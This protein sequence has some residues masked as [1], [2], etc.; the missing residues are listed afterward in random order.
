MK[1]KTTG[2][3]LIELLTVIAI[4]GILAGIIIPVVGSVRESANK[5]KTKTMFSQWATALENFRQEYGYYPA[6][7][8][9][10]GKTDLSN[11]GDRAK[12][13]HWLTGE[14]ISGYEGEPANRRGMSFYSFSESELLSPDSTTTDF[15]IKNNPPIY[16][17]FGNDTIHIVVDR[18]R[19]GI[20]PEEDISI[21][22]NDV[23]S[24]VVI[25]SVPDPDKGFVLVRNWSADLE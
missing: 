23:R 17:T 10:S 5:T 13:F 4:I 19:D 12:F 20:I 2:F 16:D 1:K 8:P 18:D 24:P 25:Y 14:D 7:D 9:E 15:D 22:K 6:A 3:T 11:E 21:S